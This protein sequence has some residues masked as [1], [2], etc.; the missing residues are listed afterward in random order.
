LLLDDRH[1]LEH[2][3]R[4][5]GEHLV[6]TI[7]TA[8][9]SLRVGAQQHRGIMTATIGHRL[10]RHAVI[11]QKRLVRPSQVVKSQLRKAELARQPLE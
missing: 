7:V 5:S 4:Q 11:E 6:R 9:G 10:Q 1:I 2:A 8:L 3:F